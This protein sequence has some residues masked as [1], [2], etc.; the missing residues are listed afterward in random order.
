MIN[1]LN[2]KI[3]KKQLK[4]SIIG[5]GYVGLPI[6]LAFS[7]YFQVYGFDIDVKRISE[8]KKG[9]DRN[10]IS[11]SKLT[12]SKKLSFTSNFKNLIDSDFFIITVPTPVGKNN[13][14]DL[15]YLNRAIKTLLKIDLK[16]KFIVI[17]STVYPTLCER[18]IKLIEK[19]KKLKVNKDFCFGFSPERINPSDTIYTLKNIDKIVSSSSKKSLYLL[20]KLY[21]KIIN[22][23]HSS[24][25]INDAEM[26][27]IIENTQRDINIAFINEISIICKKLN[28]NF[29][30]V[31]K[32]A[33]TKWNFLRF[34]PG[35]VGGHCISVDPY[36][37]TYVLKK[38]KYDPKVILS[39]RGVNENY[40]N[41]IFQFIKERFISKK[42]KILLAGITYKED[43]NDIRNSKAI[44]LANKLIG[45]YKYVDVF[46][47]NINL[48]KIN[49][50]NL[51]E[52][53]KKNFYDLIV[54]T[55]RHK[56]FLKNSKLI[57]K[58]FGKKKSFIYDVKAGGLID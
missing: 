40:S 19:K 14:P 45:R 28:L 31:M 35:L 38:I 55:V 3:D 7:K 4:I 25:S 17:E 6:A 18:Y 30:N 15:S 42:T 5:L 21:S 11:N 23:I 46:D 43:C 32:L 48:G 22:R 33:S 53:P 52:K 16:K 9:I 50:M 10:E 26:A 54:I 58:K 41:F 56:K 49:N 57:L 44:I 24:N 27:K 2:K 34:T 8:L 20:K 1:L 29:Q 37:L 51:V 39:G 47:P 12:S 36:Y 13:I